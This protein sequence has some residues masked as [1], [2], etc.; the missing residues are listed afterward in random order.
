MSAVAEGT[1]AWSEE[2]VP[3]SYDGW[4]ALAMPLC[5]L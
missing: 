3:R 5:S 1:W 2:A 4:Q